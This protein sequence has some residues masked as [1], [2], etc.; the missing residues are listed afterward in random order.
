MATVTALNNFV[1]LAKLGPAPGN[2]C[3]TVVVSD[4]RWLSQDIL[5]QSENKTHYL[6]NLAHFSVDGFCHLTQATLLAF[7]HGHLKV[8]FLNCEFDWN[9]CSVL[10]FVTDQT[11]NIF[12]DINV[13]INCDGEFMFCFYFSTNNI[14]L[15]LTNYLSSRNIFRK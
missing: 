6:C 13:H 1:P 15:N 8:R 14:H 4:E 3:T 9:L 5:C 10:D 2:S 12:L 7:A 11:R